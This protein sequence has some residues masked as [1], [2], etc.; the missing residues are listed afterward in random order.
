MPH[1]IDQPG[2]PDKEP[3]AREMLEDVIRRPE[4]YESDSPD[5]LQRL[6]DTL[7]SCGCEEIPY[8]GVTMGWAEG[9]G[10]ENKTA[11]LLVCG[12]Q[13]VSVHLGSENRY[14]ISIEVED[15]GAPTRTETKAAY[16]TR[17]LRLV[18]RLWK[19]TPRAADIWNNLIVRYEC[20]RVREAFRQTQHPP[21]NQS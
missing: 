12:R 3:S 1:R 8:G 10:G 4:L 17:D 6:R 19:A 5:A 18:E 14:G 9:E 16:D 2:L 15:I 13:L 21:E 20:E 11:A 7:N